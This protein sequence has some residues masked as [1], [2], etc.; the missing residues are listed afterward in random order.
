M[1]RFLPQAALRAALLVTAATTGPAFADDAGSQPIPEGHAPAGVMVDHM[2]KAGEFMVGYRYSYSRSS[3]DTLAG[4]RTVDDHEIMHNACL[5]P[6]QNPA[7][8]GTHNHCSMKQDKMTMQ[9]HMLDIMYAPTDWLTLMVMPQWMTMNMTM[10]PLAGAA[11]GHDEH[12]EH[13]EAAHGE[14]GH[15]G[16]H[17]GPHS[18]GTDGF[19]DTIFGA[20][21]KIT[22]GPGYH[23]HTGMMFSAP[24]G[25]TDKKAENGNYTHYMM[26]I[27]SGTWDFLPSLTYTGRADRWSWGI[28]LS[29]VI[30]M[31]D[32]NNE[33]YRLGDVFQATG[34]GAY[35]FTDWM[36][37]SVRLVHTT[38]G[39]IEG[40]YNG[41]HN[42]SSPPDLQPNYGGQFFDVG[43][44]MNF[45][46]P[47]GVLKGHRLSV[48][49]LQPVRDNPNGYQQE[50]DG[51][52]YANWSKAF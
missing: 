24:T 49:W 6:G 7:D 2:H 40:H 50:R 16:G 47:D 39:E 17:D 3:G 9:M 31:E 25:A 52:L 10:T 27:G 11:G 19:G 15:G 46:V 45:V 36:S 44:G 34:W 42:H 1:S 18:H 26:Q 28:Q 43:F 51:T 29:G 38:Q 8:H 5:L 20:L 12:D 35:R 37:A 4:T 32:E 21:I 48:E 14:H 13:G 30:R 41:P 33:G 23:L 22:D